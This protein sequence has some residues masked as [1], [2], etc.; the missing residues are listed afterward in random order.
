M[1][2]LFPYDEHYAK[3][4]L[5]KKV[6][7][8]MT[9]LTPERLGEIRQFTINHARSGKEIVCLSELLAHIDALEG[10]LLGYYR[11]AGSGVW[12][13]TSKYSELVKDRDQLKTANRLLMDEKEQFYLRLQEENQ[14]LKKRIVALEK[15]MRETL[16]EIERGKSKHCIGCCN[17]NDLPEEELCRACWRIWVDKK[18]FLLWDWKRT[19]ARYDLTLAAD[20]QEEGK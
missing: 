10:E 5:F 13:E 16:K 7:S 19:E 18:M 2:L 15:E 4:A 8:N 17:G 20:D 11:M 14:R 6:V 1:I 12:I 3:Q 9:K